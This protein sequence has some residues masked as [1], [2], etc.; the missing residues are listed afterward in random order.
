[1]Q[2]ALTPVFL[3]FLTSCGGEQ[4]TKSLN[5]TRA[6]EAS[7]AAGGDHERLV[8]QL[9]LGFLGRPA[10]PGGL[11]YYTQALRN[12]NAPTTIPGLIDAYRTNETVRILMSS[13]ADSEESRQLYPYCA[14]IGCDFTWVNAL[15]GSLFSRDPDIEGAEFW[16]RALNGKG[17]GRA[18]VLL[19]VL[20]AAQGS[21]A[22]LVERKIRMAMQFTR[23]IELSGQHQVY[24]GQIAG[25]ITRAMMNSSPGLADDAAIQGMVDATVERLARLSSGAVEELAPGSRKLLLLVSGERM[26]DNGS[27]LLALAYAMQNDLNQLRPDGPAWSVSVKEAARSISGIR[28]QLRSYDGA[29]LVGQLPVP[30]SRGAP[31]LDVYRLPDCPHYRMSDNGEVLNGLEL[32]PV[33]VRCRNGLVVSV[34]RGRDQYAEAAEI[35]SKLDQMIAYHSG[36]SAANASWTRRFQLIEAIWATGPEMQWGDLSS[37]WSGMSLFPANAI[38]YL[39]AGTSIQRRDA[40]LACIGQNTEMCAASLHGSPQS[41][42]FEG[43]G[44]AGSSTPATRPTGRRGNLPR[45]SSRRSMWSSPPAAPRTFCTKTRSAPAS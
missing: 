25:A 45:D 16:T 5:A 6:M 23:T 14:W 35:R 40:F 8:Q 34:L 37:L 3:V 36:S 39:N 12:A 29:I 19:S 7:R 4:E 28:N 2:L 27:R 9:Y 22:E 11:A 26:A 15:Y 10:D 18:T 21:D 44:Q 38:S 20:A 17:A 30:A 31:F 13:F 41:L 24:S 32:R 1:M 33:D 42:M 43:P